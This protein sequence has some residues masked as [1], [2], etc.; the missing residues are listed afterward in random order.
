MWYGAVVAKVSEDDELARAWHELMGKYQRLTCNLDRE[1]HA[2]HGISAS[3]FEVLQQLY[4]ATPKRSLRMHDLGE[5]VHLTQSALSRLVARLERDGLIERCMCFE[6][7]RSV[8]AKITPAGIERYRAA[9]PTQRRIL[10]EDA[11][12]CLD[13]VPAPSSR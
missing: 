13:K 4:G 3:D 9:R 8:W 11:T 12:G 5:H 2:E 1:L 10:R 7:R 6:D